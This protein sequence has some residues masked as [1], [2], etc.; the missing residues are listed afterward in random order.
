MIVTA[1]DIGTHKVCCVIGRIH[2]EKQGRFVV[3]VLGAAKQSS[4]GVDAG[5][6]V[7][8]QALV[9]ILREVI[10]E[11]S[12]MAGVSPNSVYVN[13][14]GEYVTCFN[15]KGIVSLSPSGQAQ[16]IRRVDVERV[17]ESARNGLS[18]P[19]GQV[20]LHM[21]PQQF[22]VDDLPGVRNPVDMEGSKLEADF[23]VV[24]VP[25]TVIS[26]MNR[27]MELTGLRTAR[28]ILGPLA[29]AYGVTSD[30]EREQGVLIADIGAGTT[31]IVI[32]KNQSVYHTAI[33][34][35]GGE[36]FTLDIANVLNT[37]PTEAERLKRMIGAGYA[38]ALQSTP[39]SNNDT[40]S[41][42]ES[43]DL[44]PV[45]TLE[46]RA[47]PQMVPRRKIAEIIEARAEELLYYIHQTVEYVQMGDLFNRVV[48]TGG[49]ALLHDLIGM[50]SAVFESPIRLGYP[51]NIEG[52]KDIVRSPVYAVACGMMQLVAH[53]EQFRKQVHAQP[54]GWKRLWRWL[55]DMIPLLT[56]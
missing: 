12:K 35:I 38:H 36:H 22:I 48:F 40:T 14:N 15:V 55:R 26:N 41:D 54:R 3:E 19:T 7:D 34:P 30:F 10:L 56:L 1:L 47:T 52:L 5:R 42:Q 9:G 53:D 31:G 28:Y 24:T 44:V 16:P 13:I 8:M 32:M 51:I 23:H 27:L 20:I 49:G 6:I 25:H 45:P 18:L 43:G 46:P 50:A 29:A 37:S 33:L 4:A 2:E 21:V 39:S 17:R 11:A